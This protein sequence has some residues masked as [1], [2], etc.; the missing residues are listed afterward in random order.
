MS[1]PAPAGDVRLVDRVCDE[2]EAEWRRRF[3]VY[4]GDYPELAEEFERIV[5]RRLPE[6]WDAD[7]P[8]FDASGTMTATRKS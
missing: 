4:R 6:G 3:G 1:G 5:A 7:V 2:F 8:R